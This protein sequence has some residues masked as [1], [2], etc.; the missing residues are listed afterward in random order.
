MIDIDEQAIVDKL[1]AL[2]GVDTALPMATTTEVEASASDKVSDEPIATKEPKATDAP[3]DTED[4]NEPEVDK[5]VDYKRFKKI[6]ARAK[7]LERKLAERDER[8]ARAASNDSS[9]GRD[10][11][12]DDVD[13]LIDQVALGTSRTTREDPA[14]TD[15]RK[16]IQ[17]DR[18]D[19]E[20]DEVTREFPEVHLSHAF[21]LVAEDPKMS[22]REAASKLAAQAIA[23]E[24]F[25]L[26][27]HRVKTQGQPKEAP[28]KPQAPPDLGSTKSGN[29]TDKTKTNAIPKTHDDLEQAVL[30]KLGLA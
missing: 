3:K 18:L 9:K 15:L 17:A 2:E 21:A 12:R 1:L 20:R 28:A 25:V 4:R 30:K 29:A 13:D 8:D 14:I 7:E 5:P 27:K 23:Y 16:T 19:R 24:E 10:K 11:D 6:W 22:L 26:N